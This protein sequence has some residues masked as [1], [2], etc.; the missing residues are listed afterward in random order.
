M[1]TRLQLHEVLCDILGTRQV[2]FQPPESVRMKYPSIVYSLERVDKR[3]ADDTGY[4]KTRRYQV[5]Y[6]SRD[7][8]N[9]VIDRLLDLPYSSFDRRFVVDNLY[10]D[11]VALYF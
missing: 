2:Y 5:Q 3:K 9:E 8:D 4:L 11:C 1:A 10:H 6:I 7:P